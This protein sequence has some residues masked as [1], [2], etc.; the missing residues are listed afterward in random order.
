MEL[1][2]L[3]SELPAVPAVDL[4]RRLSQA[5]AVDQEHQR[6]QLTRRIY[7]SRKVLRR[8]RAV[9]EATMY[10]FPAL[11]FGVVSNHSFDGIGFLDPIFLG[12][13]AALAFLCLGSVLLGL[14]VKK[15]QLEP[16]IAQLASFAAT[17]EEQRA[18]RK[19]RNT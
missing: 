10:A 14:S 3:A 6:Q 19:L 2:P 13:G 15:F 11:L 7:R 9:F 4:T 5:L 18:V 12:I 16:Q 1:K 17:H 8:T